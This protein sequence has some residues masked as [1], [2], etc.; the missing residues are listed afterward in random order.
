MS[1]ILAIEI[2][3]WIITLSSLFVTGGIGFY[4]VQRI[5]E[6]KK[7]NKDLEFQESTI[8][9]SNAEVE[10]V[11]AE[12]YETNTKANAVVV[13][14]AGEEI[15]VIKVLHIYLLTICKD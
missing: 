15:G 2:P 6:R 4:I 3:T 14:I 12:A 5:V 11:K 7:F 10:K 1:N 13:K 8:N 9:K